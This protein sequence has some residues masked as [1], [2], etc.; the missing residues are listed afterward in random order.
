MGNQLLMEG[1]NGVLGAPGQGCNFAVLF[2]VRSA[3]LIDLPAEFAFQLLNL[4]FH[5]PN[6]V[7]Q[8]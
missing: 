1:L 7:A 6:F 4:N 3:L 5:L 8:V 2:L